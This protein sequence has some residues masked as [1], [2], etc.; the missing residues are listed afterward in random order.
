MRADPNGYGHG[1]AGPDGPL[2]S[3]TWPGST[4]SREAADEP[5]KRNGR[6]DLEGR[7]ANALGEALAC[8]YNRS[9]SHRVPFTPRP[10]LALTLRSLLETLK[11]LTTRHRRKLTLLAPGL[12]R[13]R[14]RIAAEG[15][16]AR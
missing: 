15:Y 16:A 13:R 11:R 8:S 3:R 12:E 6:S 10:P 14:P 2:R 9:L 4:G 1:T 7:Q 5:G